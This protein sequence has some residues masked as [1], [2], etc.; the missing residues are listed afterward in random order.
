MPRLIRSWKL[1]R[2]IGRIF[3]STSLEGFKSF[4]P[5]DFDMLNPMVHLPNFQIKG[6]E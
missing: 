3:S 4:I 1:C 6:L 5:D 2:E